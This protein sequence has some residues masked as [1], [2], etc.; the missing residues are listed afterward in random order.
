MQ[1]E[2]CGAGLRRAHNPE[3]AAFEA[4][5]CLSVHLGQGPNPLP[6]TQAT[7]VCSAFWS[8]RVG[9]R[10]GWLCSLPAR[11]TTASLA[12]KAEPAGSSQH[13]LCDLG[14]STTCLAMCALVCDGS[15]SG[16]SHDEAEPRQK[17]DNGAPTRRFWRLQDGP[18]TPRSEIEASSLTLRPSY[19]RNETDLR[20]EHERREW[21]R[22][23]GD[24]CDFPPKNRITLVVL[25]APTIVALFPIFS[26]CRASN[27]PRRFFLTRLHSQR[28]NIPLVGRNSPRS[29]R[30]VLLTL[31]PSHDK[32]QRRTKRRITLVICC[33][34]NVIFFCC[35]CL[36]RRQM[37]G[38][39]F[40]HPV[41]I[42]EIVFATTTRL[43]MQILHV[44]RG[45]LVKYDVF[46]VRT[47]VV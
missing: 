3:E 16:S 9:T 2:S 27:R 31:G 13:T 37:C 42:T 32:E 44:V 46:W 17:W 38:H 11:S 41:T 30:Y 25:L 1:W 15:S 24:T 10:G 12:L 35:S 21:R 19:E 39:L 33:S 28:S 18:N 7:S 36:Q 29:V 26:F 34:R 22:E 43:E 5:S 14:P 6:I 47:F 20:C 23:K 8:W 45:S 40:F 4:T